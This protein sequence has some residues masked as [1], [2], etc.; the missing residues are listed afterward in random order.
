MLPYFEITPVVKRLIIAHTA[1][2]LLLVSLLQRFFMENYGIFHIFGLSPGE[3]ALG[4]RVW[5][6]FTYMFIHAQGAFHVALN[7]FMLWMF[8]SELERNWGGRKFFHYYLFCGAGA[9]L[10]YTI[11][12]AGYVLLGGGG[13]LLF[14][15]MIGA[16]GA[17]FGLLL[18]YGTI[19][20]ERIIYF[21]MIFPMK[22]KTFIWILAAIEL[23]SIMENGF[24]GPVANLGHLGGFGCG[25]LF[26]KWRPIG[27][28]LAKF[29]DAL[30]FKRRKG[31]LSLL[32]NR[33]ERGKTPPFHH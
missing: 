2:W 6:F 30:P 13:S 20:S 18:A 31:L 24:S 3:A 14:R 15:P 1:I 17:I 4:G 5:Q 7:M 19:Y 32:K 21:M 26:L 33:G 10:L 9:G 8:G 27:D 29:K 25:L 12:I 16:S 22:A 11:C 23:M 28:W